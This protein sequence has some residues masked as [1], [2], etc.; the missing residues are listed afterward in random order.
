M[1]MFLP[2]YSENWHC[3]EI[4]AKINVELSVFTKILIIV[5]KTFAEA[6]YLDDKRYGHFHN[7]RN[8]TNIFVRKEY[9][10][11]IIGSIGEFS[12][13]AFSHQPYV[14]NTHNLQILLFGRKIGEKNGSMAMVLQD[15]NYLDTSNKEMHT[16]LENHSFL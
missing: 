11:R 7:K 15:S 13:K 4:S 16:S 12:W 10:S 5:A 1:F 8:F 3:C 9:F 2:G 6:D 14:Q